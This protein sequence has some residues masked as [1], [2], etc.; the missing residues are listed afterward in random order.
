MQNET[1]SEKITRVLIENGCPAGAVVRI[2]AKLNARMPGA[3]T[4]LRGVLLREWPACSEEV[5]DILTSVPRESDP[6]EIQ[7][8]FERIFIANGESREAAA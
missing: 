3:P 5:V 7:E 1:R 6:T 2:A 8:S 4:T